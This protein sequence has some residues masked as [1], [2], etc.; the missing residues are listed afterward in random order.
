L[1]A[2][3]GWLGQPTNFGGTLSTEDYN[4][5]RQDGQ[6]LQSLTNPTP[7]VITRTETIVESNP[8]VLGAAVGLVVALKKAEANRDEWRVYAKKLEC[9]IEGFAAN[10]DALRDEITHCTAPH[11]LR[12][13]AEQLK[14]YDAAYIAE[15]KKQGLPESQ[16][17]V[18]V[19]SRR[20]QK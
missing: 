19:L 8:E 13:T 10:R 2:D 14:L 11:P 17:D 20:G 4:R 5:G 3:S 16:W 18:T 7:Q 12:E 9:R 1:L 6:Y 15:A